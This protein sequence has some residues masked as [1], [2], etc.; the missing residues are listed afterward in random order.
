[1]GLGSWGPCAPHAFPSP[2]RPVFQVAMDRPLQE[3]ELPHRPHHSPLTSCPPL[4]EGSPL[5]RASHRATVPPHSSVSHAGPWSGR[6]QPGALASHPE[7]HP[8]S[9]CLAPAWTWPGC[10]QSRPSAQREVGHVAGAFGPDLVVPQRGACTCRELQCQPSACPP[11]RLR[12]A[13][14][15]LGGEARPSWC[16]GLRQQ[17]GALASSTV[18]GGCGFHVPR[19]PH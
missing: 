15:G 8:C 1:M 2:L 17:G 7:R 16:V 14:L 11:A 9:L 13:V 5:L 3:E 6:G 12:G 19:G 4:P 18:A 10:C